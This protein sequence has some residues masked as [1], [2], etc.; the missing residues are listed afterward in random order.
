MRAVSLSLAIAIAIAIFVA[1]CSGG[2][3]ADD[4]DAAPR[5]D[6][7]AY[8][9]GGLDFGNLRLTEERLEWGENGRAFGL[10]SAAGF[11]SYHTRTMDEGPCELFE[12]E[13]AF[14]EEPC[15]GVC[16]APN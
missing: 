3:G 9:D 1:G 15:N 14:C 5:P 13:Q 7:Q 12:F 8:P 10:F 4:P 16:T 11:P 6:A 2:A